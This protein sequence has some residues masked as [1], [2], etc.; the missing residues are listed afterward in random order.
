LDPPNL[1][2][3][4]T[5]R[6]ELLLHLKANLAKAQAFMKIFADKKRRVLEFQVGDLVLVKLQPYRRYSVA[7]RKNQ[8]LGL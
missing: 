7:F 2:K 1:Q 8:K 5:G 3:L 6:D 4:L